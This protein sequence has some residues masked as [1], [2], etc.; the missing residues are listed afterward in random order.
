MRSLEDRARRLRLAKPIATR[1]DTGVG[2]PAA[3][4]AAMRQQI[5]ELMIQEAARAQVK[6][7]AEKRRAQFW[8]WVRTIGLPLAT[9]A[10]EHIW[11]H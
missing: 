7:A 11:R 1:E 4:L 9:L 2:M 3:E 10:A 8:E 5:Q 6:T